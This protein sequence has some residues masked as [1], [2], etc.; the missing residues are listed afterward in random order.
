MTRGPLT[1]EMVAARIRVREKRRARALAM[2]AEEMLDALIN[3]ETNSDLG[4]DPRMGG[5]TDCYLVT[6][7][8]MDA[9]RAAI[10]KARGRG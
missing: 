7:D 2:A 4:P 9:I 1:A 8:D 10:A 5:L 6:I 3:A